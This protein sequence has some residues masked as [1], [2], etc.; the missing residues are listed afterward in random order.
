MSFYNSATHTVKVET[1]TEAAD[2]L[3]AADTLGLTLREVKVRGWW[4]ARDGAEP[5]RGSTWSL[6]SKTREARKWF[7]LAGNGYQ[8][9]AAKPRDEG[10][11]TLTLRFD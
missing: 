8:T 3:E 5:S 1:P 9:F 7:H 4:E 10:D 2:A 11:G 6:Q